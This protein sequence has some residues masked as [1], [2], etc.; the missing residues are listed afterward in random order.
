MVFNLQSN[1]KKDKEPAQKE[2]LFNFQVPAELK[3]FKRSWLR[4]LESA[5]NIPR[6]IQVLIH[7]EAVFFLFFKYEDL[8]YRNIQ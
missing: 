2:R 5:T 8:D 4:L 7:N 1:K 3:Y 6:N